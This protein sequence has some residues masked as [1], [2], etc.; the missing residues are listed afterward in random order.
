MRSCF[1]VLAVLVPLVAC[2]TAR[3]GTYD[4][5]SCRLPDGSPAPTNGWS[6]F[7][8]P[9]PEIGVNTADACASGGTLNA[10]LP[11]FAPIGMEVGWVFTPPPGSAV[12]GFELFRAISPAGFPIGAIGGYVATLGTWPASDPQGESDESCLGGGAPNTPPCFGGIGI[13][14][15]AFDQSNRYERQGIHASRLVLGLG[16]WNAFNPAG[17]ECNSAASPA[18]SQG[19]MVF[20]AKLTLRDD[21]APTVEHGELE[22]VARGVMRAAVT[23]L[24]EGA[25]LMHASLVIDGAEADR[26]PLDGLPAS[27][28]RPFVDPVPCPLHRDL[29]IPFDSRGVAE[30]THIVQVAVFDAAG[31]RGLSAPMSVLVANGGASVSPLPGPNGGN[32]T[33]FARLRAWLAGRSRRSDRTLS[34]GATTSVDGQLKTSGGAPIAGATLQ[35]EQRDI[36]V[37]SRPTRLASVTT[38]ASGRFTYR[39]A[40]GA[41]RSLRFSYTAF[42]GDAGPVASA[43]VSVHVRAGVS[44]KAS[45]PRVRNGTFLTFKGRVLGER[46][47]RRAVV[48]IYALTRGPRP[49]IPVETFRAAASGRFTYRYRFRS[50][51]GPVVYRFEARVLKQTGFPYVEGASRPVAVHGRP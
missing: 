43:Q 1:L 11:P 17:A 33:R 12:E 39:V 18:P 5:Y 8:N 23:V 19:L 46:G 22:A 10:S 31:N 51:P 26:H 15:S 29:S 27:C 49:R 14:G 34:Y 30:G 40:R 20:A 41:S 32:A 28:L 44:L 50:I 35:V 24:D 16:C 2:A 38:D 42:P 37:S 47:T 45:P 7:A 21:L 36:G 48:T 9:A 6:A 4:V 25:G 13:T 3:A